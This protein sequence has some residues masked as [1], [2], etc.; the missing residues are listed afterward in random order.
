V[1][2]KF[3]EASA[4]LAKELGEIQLGGMSSAHSKQQPNALYQ[5]GM[6]YRRGF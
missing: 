5:L 1:T 4:E 3:L 2:S 6:Y